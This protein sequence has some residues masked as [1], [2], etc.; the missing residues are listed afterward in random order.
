[1]GFYRG[2]VTGTK[3]DTEE[4]VERAFLAASTIE[5]LKASFR[6][7]EIVFDSDDKKLWSTSAGIKSISNIVSQLVTRVLFIVIIFPL[8]YGT[9]Q[10]FQASHV[11]LLLKLN[12]QATRLLTTAFVR[13]G[14]S[15]RLLDDY[16]LLMGRGNTRF[17]VALSA[18]EM[19]Y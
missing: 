4:K 5:E 18:R 19:D 11:Y 16:I 10:S 6:T 7:M 8:P 12:K 17:G 3:T 1:M 2:L 15:E 13:Q 9:L 14:T